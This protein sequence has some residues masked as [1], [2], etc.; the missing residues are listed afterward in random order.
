MLSS[1][2]ELEI[3]ERQEKWS[4]VRVITNNDS[5]FEGWVLNQYLMERIPYESQAMALS[6][7]NRKL[8]ENL[9]KLNREQTST[10]KDKN[11][12]SSQYDQ[13]LS[14]LTSLKKA[15][16]SLKNASSEYLSLKDEYD[17]NLLK[18]ETT[19]KRLNEVEIENASIKKSQN[20]IW[21]GT[22]AL[23]LLFGLVIGSILGRQSR[24]RNSSYF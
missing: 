22:G 14:E 15:Y 12:I 2:Q 24:N 3:L 23:V 21:F 17:K 18:M 13:T 20:Y 6:S 19:E 9:T 16:E 4:H 1:G 7:E 5:E 11:E 10:E 8:K